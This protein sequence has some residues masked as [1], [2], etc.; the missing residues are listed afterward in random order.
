MCRKARRRADPPA[1]VP[2]P[3]PNLR[4]LETW[5][6]FLKGELDEE[7]RRTTSTRDRAGQSVSVAGVLGVLITG[8]IELLR[9]PGDWTWPST[10]TFVVFGVALLVSIVLALLAGRN[11]VSEVTSRGIIA[12]IP[13][14]ADDPDPTTAL[15]DVVQRYSKDII[16]LRDANDSI[17]KALRHAHSWLG[18]AVAWGILALCVVLL[19]PALPW[20]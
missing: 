8:A 2:E 10:V 20:F 11:V 3:Y 4:S 15:R 1:I 6:T 14:W 18:V 9:P 17:V 13:G 19:G 16:G 12:E 5:T 7:R